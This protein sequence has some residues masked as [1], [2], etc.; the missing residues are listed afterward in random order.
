MRFSHL[1]GGGYQINLFDDTE[2]QISLYQAM[3]KVRLRFGEDKVQRAVGMK[4]K[5]HKMNPFN[6]VVS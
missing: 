4:I 2:E 3:D 5:H 6:G 1:V